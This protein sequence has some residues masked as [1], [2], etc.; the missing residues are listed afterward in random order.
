VG[1]ELNGTHQLLVYADEINLL[2]DIVNTIKKSSDALNGA[3]YELSREVN[4]EK[5]SIY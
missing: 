1:V 2:G 4:A 3:R 5:L